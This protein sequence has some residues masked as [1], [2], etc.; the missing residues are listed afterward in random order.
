MTTAWCLKDEA[1]PLADAVL[2][3][4]ATDD[5]V[6]PAIWGAEV[7]NALLAAEKRGRFSPGETPAAV[8]LLRRLPIHAD[9]TDPRFQ[10]DP[11]IQLGRDSGLS[12]Y[13]ASYL[14]LA[15]RTGFPLATLDGP[16]RLACQ[17]MSVR[18][19]SA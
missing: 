4:L 14:H 16:L 15:Q 13:D 3:M 2:E 7:A 11:L 9:A 10:M 1:S 8:A 5:A 17:R 12:I 18:T 19:V 6:V